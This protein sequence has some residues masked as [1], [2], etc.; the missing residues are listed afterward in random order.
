ME[1]QIFKCGTAWQL[2]GDHQHSLT[3]LITRIVRPNYPGWFDNVTIFGR[4]VILSRFWLRIYQT[5]IDLFVQTNRSNCSIITMPAAIGEWANELC[6]GY[7]S[8]QSSK[9][10]MFVF[11]AIDLILISTQRAHMKHKFNVCMSVRARA[12]ACVCVYIVLYLPSRI[13]VRSNWMKCWWIENLNDPCLTWAHMYAHSHIKHVLAAVKLPS[14]YIHIKLFSI[15]HIQHSYS[16]VVQNVWCWYVDIPP[17]DRKIYS[18]L[19]IVY[20]FWHFVILIL[21]FRFC[22]QNAIAIFHSTSNLC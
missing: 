7:Y 22:F 4:A 5:Q 9:P 16:A 20:F 14:I 10:E 21:A 13:S 19:A 12:R 17:R 1:K 6:A 18:F 2:I 15:S 11:S 8:V 3:I